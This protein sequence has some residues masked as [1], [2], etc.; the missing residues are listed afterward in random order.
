[1]GTQAYGNVHISLLPLMIMRLSES[2]FKFF[3]KKLGIYLLR[4]WIYSRI[5]LDWLWKFPEYSSCDWS[6]LGVSMI[7]EITFADPVLAMGAAKQSKLQVMEGDGERFQF[8]LSNRKSTEVPPASPHCNPY[9]SKC[10][11]KN[12]LFHSRD[13]VSLP[14]ANRA[15][16]ANMLPEN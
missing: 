9:T 12:H 1:M 8:I 6:N 15:T 13:L 10:N 11:S 16:L 4:V 5:D 14:D 7:L 3:K 2:S